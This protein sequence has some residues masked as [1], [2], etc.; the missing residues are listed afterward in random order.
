MS[1]YRYSARSTSL[2]LPVSASEGRRTEK[3]GYNRVVMY[4]PRWLGAPAL[5]AVALG[6]LSF[7]SPR[8]VWLNDGFHAS[9]PPSR[10]IFALVAATGACVLAL[11]LRSRL[12]QAAGL[13]V[14]AAFTGLSLLVGLW[15][16]DVTAD[17]ISVRTLW[18]TTLVRWADVA[19]LDTERD[20]V[21]VWPRAGKPLLVDMGT[22]APADRAPLERAV[23][24]R[25]REAAV[26]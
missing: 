12:A 16:L 13:L 2:P 9:H 18:G 5:V 10:W 1:F 22:L 25:V 7:G 11:T 8:S 21:V 14:A 20:R 6:V 23:A 4:L 24:R 3:A 19:R 17:R 15:R 26:R